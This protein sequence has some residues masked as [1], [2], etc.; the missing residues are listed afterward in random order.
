MTV[1]EAGSVYKVDEDSKIK[2]AASIYFSNFIKG[3]KL[4]DGNFQTGW[5]DNSLDSTG[6]LLYDYNPITMSAEY[7][8]KHLLGM[9]PGKI[10]LEFAQNPGA[11]VQNK[12]YVMGVQI[13]D[14]KL[15]EAG[16]WQAQL[17][18]TRLERDA[19][20]DMLPDSGAYMGA[21]NFKGAYLT[22]RYVVATNTVAACRI[23]PYLE[24]ISGATNP[25]QM[26]QLDFMVN[27]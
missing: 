1:L 5:A 25:Q 10:M 21:T 4:D 2:V 20:L 22:A 15:K 9:I 11:P 6:A 24:K 13:G 8:H 18:Y 7:V 23:S 16:K 3:S 26:V 12:A 19:W 14:D 27:F 17:I